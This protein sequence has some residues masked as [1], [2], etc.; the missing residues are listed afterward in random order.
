MTVL[1]RQTPNGE[2]P[3]LTTSSMK[4][5]HCGS[6]NGASGEL[7]AISAARGHTGVDNGRHE[8][9]GRRESICALAL[10][11]RERKRDH[12]PQA[13]LGRISQADAGAVGVGDLLDDGKPEPAAA[14]RAAAGGVEAEEGVKHGSPR[15]LGLPCLTP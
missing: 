4:F 3:N 5:F 10:R 13:A 15:V 12:R 9:N 14:G 6:Y 1:Q 7:R 11:G 8:S 2:Q